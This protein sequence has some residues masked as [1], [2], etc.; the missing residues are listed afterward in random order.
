MAIESPNRPEAAQGWPGAKQ[1]SHRAGGGAK[2][3][4]LNGVVETETQTVVCCRFAL[5]LLNTSPGR[6]TASQDRAWN[7]LWAWNEWL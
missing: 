1:S 7:A 3:G 2:A 6:K 5:A 4:L